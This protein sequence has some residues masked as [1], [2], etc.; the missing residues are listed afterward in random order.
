MLLAMG[1][2]ETWDLINYG[3]SE[4]RIAINQ[5][6]A[7][8]PGKQLVFVRYG[9]QHVFR[10]WV[11]NAADIDGAPI[12]W[13]LDLGADEDQ[14]LERYYP[15]RAVWVVEPDAR[16]PRLVRISGP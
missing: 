10:E 1:R 16:P 7:D 13:A 8:A 2:Y 15:G 4:G 9:P 11:H 12:V 6:L 3:D 5:R 14:Q